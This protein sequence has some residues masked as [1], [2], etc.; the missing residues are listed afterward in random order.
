MRLGSA[1]LLVLVTCVALPAAKSEAAG[2]RVA[3]E[4]A[5]AG[6]SA[7][8]G[9]TMLVVPTGPLSANLDLWETAHGATIRDY[10]LDMTKRLHMIVVSDDFTS[11]QHVHPKLGAN[12][13]FTIALRV[14]KPARYYVFA[15]ADPAGAGKQVFRFPVLFGRAPPATA[16]IGPA[17]SSAAAGPYLVTLSSLNLRAA[18]PTDLGVRIT[19]GGSLATDLRP[20]LGAAAHAVFVNVATLDYV[21]VHPMTGASTAPAMGGMDGMDMPG[22]AA[23]AMTSLPDNAKVPGSMTLHVSRVPAGTYKLWL[24]FRGGDGLQTAAFVLSTS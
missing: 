5:L 20:Y 4:F 13:H 23:P 15:D 14:P 21:H 11:F 17:S 6:A 19:K 18:G 1:A 12:G 8:A 24:Q 22:M 2:I 16:A 7:K 10:A 3:G 9:A